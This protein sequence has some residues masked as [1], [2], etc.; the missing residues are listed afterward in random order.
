M[1]DNI[2]KDRFNISADELEARMQKQQE[3]HN[4]PCQKAVM[5]LEAA[6]DKV[7]EKLGVN[8]TQVYPDGS[9]TVA[10]QMNALGIIM[11]E[12]TDERSPQINGFFIFVTRNCDLIPYAWVG[13]ARINHNGECFADIQWFVDNR[14]DETGGVKLIKG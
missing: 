8:T 5:I 10:D 7:L 9:S 12:N 13:A 14:L 11:T 6:L 4:E 2:I 3:L 1:S